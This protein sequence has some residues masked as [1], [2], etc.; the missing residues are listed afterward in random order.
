MVI[1]LDEMNFDDEVFQEDNPIFVDFW[2]DWCFPCK[3]LAPTFEKIA[4]EYQKKEGNKVRF[5]KVNIAENRG[6][7]D[8][9]KEKDIVIMHIPM[10]ILF[11]QK[12][13]V[14]KIEGYME[15][16][17]LRSSMEELLKKTSY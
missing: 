14:G 6:I 13:F 2:A 12:G 4:E 11:C 5:A 10:I 1:E 17:K 16:D 9:L 15:E 8:G 3:K 7:V